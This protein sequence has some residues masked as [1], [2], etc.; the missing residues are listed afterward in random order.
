MMEQTGARHPSLLYAI[1]QVELAVRS[2]LDELLKP[3]GVTA[4]QYTAL[5]VL[6]RRD[7]L[8]AAALARNSFVKTQSMADLV[9]AL[10]R[11]QLVSRHVDAKDRRRFL[12][13]LTPKGRKLIADHA[14]AVAEL[15]RRMTAGLATTQLDTM[16]EALN[17]CRS[18]LGDA[19]AH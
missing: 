19:P 12:I 5:T 14:S 17:T 2:H 16:R 1:K 15:E 3:S 13:Q 18:N 10:E 7:D 11:Q 4:L 9:A 6:E 8:T